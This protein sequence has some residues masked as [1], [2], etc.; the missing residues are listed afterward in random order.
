MLLP[1]MKIRV[2]CKSLLER[3]ATPVSGTPAVGAGV[4]VVV[5]G[6]GS[7]SVISTV[8][9]SVG[10]T[11]AKATTGISAPETTIAITVMMLANLFMFLV[12]PFMLMIVPI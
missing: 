9:T 6:K 7:V 5:V 10:G 8:G 3:G 1:S 11:C 12:F 4:S 2:F